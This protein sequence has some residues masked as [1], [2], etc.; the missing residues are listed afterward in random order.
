MAGKMKQVKIFIIS[1]IVL[2]TVFVNSAHAYVQP[3]TGGSFLDAIAPFAFAILL[4]APWLWTLI[5]IMTNKSSGRNKVIW[6]IVVR[7]IPVFGLILYFLMGHKK[8]IRTTAS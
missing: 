4:L 3:D 8:K 6:L 2:L 1:F 7:V 5:K